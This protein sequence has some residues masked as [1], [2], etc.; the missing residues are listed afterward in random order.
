MRNEEPSK[1]EIINL[2]SRAHHFQLCHSRVDQS[3][4]HPVPCIIFLFSN[5][6][7][8][9]PAGS[10][11]QI[12]RVSWRSIQSIRIEKSRQDDGEKFDA[13]VISCYAQRISTIVKWPVNVF[14]LFKGT[15]AK[16]IFTNGW[17][18]S[19]KWF[20]PDPRVAVSSLQNESSCTAMYTYRHLYRCAIRQIRNWYFFSTKRGSFGTKRFG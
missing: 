15:I 6:A 19:T 3:C 1:K 14:R 5:F 11:N 10:T 8:I 12:I 17:L 4:I 13:I 16:R 20:N 2:A 7:W 9:L 18:T